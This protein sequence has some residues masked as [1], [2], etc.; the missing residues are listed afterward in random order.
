M[1]GT[2]VARTH[3]A[4][5]GAVAGE[6]AGEL[7][8]E[9]TVELTGEIVGE[10]LEGF[11][12]LL[13]AVG[14]VF[15]QIGIAEDEI[16]LA[17]GRHGEAPPPRDHDNRI[18]GVRGPLWSSFHLM[19]PTHDRME[20]EIVFRVHCRELLERVAAGHDT[21]PPTNVEMLLAVAEVSLVTPM[22]GAATGLYF[23]LFARVFP[24]ES[25][26]MFA[27]APH[28]PADYEHMYGE[29]MDDHEALLLHK[30]RQPWRVPKV[31]DDLP[32]D[33]DPVA[34]EPKELARELAAPA[35][36]KPVQLSIDEVAA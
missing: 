22:T 4:S 14:A 9:I 26:R 16:E 5:D 30:L 28:T 6:P 19:V 23:R 25:A 20:T 32:A 2:E 31:G 10:V 35:P 3:G 34:V 21:R 36:A 11:S 7:V 12:D 8:G 15:D 18:I 27:D 13:T 24:A 1:T 17:Q 29:T 33:P